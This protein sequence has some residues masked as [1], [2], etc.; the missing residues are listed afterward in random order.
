MLWS[1]MTLTVK[2][3]FKACCNAASGPSTEMWCTQQAASACM[4][5]RRARMKQVSE[6]LTILRGRTLKLEI[7][8]EPRAITSLMKYRPGMRRIRIQ[9]ASRT[10][11]WS[12]QLDGA[13][14]RKGRLLQ[15]PKNLTMSPH[16][17]Y[18]RSHRARLASLA[19]RP[20]F[21]IALQVA[22]L[23]RSNREASFLGFEGRTHGLGRTSSRSKSLTFW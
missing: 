1:P 10:A 6:A 22:T 11:W 5:M 3:P 19:R 15:R 20:S 2:R 8:W 13:R 9:T 21:W 4:R 23:A 17:R 14:E 16:R 12:R 7:S 18:R